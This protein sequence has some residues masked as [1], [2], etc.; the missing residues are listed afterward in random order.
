MDRIFI[1][2]NYKSLKTPFVANDISFV[3]IPTQS[4]IQ[5]ADNS[6]ETEF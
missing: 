6:K 4:L 3:V 2:F 5:F 1:L